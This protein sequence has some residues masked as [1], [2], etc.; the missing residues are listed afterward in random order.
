[1]FIHS[2]M[3]LPSYPNRFDPEHPFTNVCPK[4]ISVSLNL[5][6]GHGTALVGIYRNSALAESGGEPIDLVDVRLGDAEGGIGEDLETFA[7]DPVFANYCA[8][9]AMYLYE[10][11]K[12]HPLFA[13]AVIS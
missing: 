13:S 12:L 4:I 2:P 7:S 8:G 10:K 1:M 6:T 9:V 5:A 3:T 11:M